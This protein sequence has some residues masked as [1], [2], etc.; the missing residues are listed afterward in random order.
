M[1]SRDGGTGKVKGLFDS[2]MGRRLQ[3]LARQRRGFLLSLGA[4]AVLSLG[5]SGCLD[6]AISPRVG[7]V[8]SGDLVGLWVMH[9]S[10]GISNDHVQLLS[11][12]ARPEREWPLTLKAIGLREWSGTSTTDLASRSARGRIAQD[13]VEWNLALVS[14][15]TVEMRWLVTGDSARGIFW[16]VN[17]DTFEADSLFGVRISTDLLLPVYSASSSPLSPDSTPQILLRLD[18]IPASDRDFVARL[19]QR[20]LVAEIA[21]PTAWVGKYGRPSWSELRAWVD[22]GFSVAA[23]SR[24]HG[25]SPSGDLAF[26]S[27]VLGSI[28]DL[29]SHGLSASVF[30]QPGTWSDSLNFNSSTKLRTWRGSLLHSFTRV[31]EGYVY[32]P[33]VGQPAPDSVSFGLS[34]VTISG[35]ASE[36][37]ILRIWS[38]AVRPNRFTVLLVHT[39]D[40]PRPDALD[41]FLDTLA[42]ARAAER[43]RVVSSPVGVLGGF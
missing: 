29:R 4:C 40:L 28:G 20:G 31:F 25:L 26:F 17:G 21:V 42:A 13:R 3:N 36:D 30:V 41:W 12:Q 9:L 5:N 16:W 11:I 6:R 7:A 38:R 35:G 27:E 23:H 1:S 34:H 10:R 39:R 14:G 24:T 22:G 32:P 18:D 37:Y 19:Q 43:I 2:L 33:P 15:D 8:R